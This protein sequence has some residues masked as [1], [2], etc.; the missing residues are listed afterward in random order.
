MQI[1]IPI[2]GTYSFGKVKND[3]ETDAS[4][5][6]FKALL[7]GYTPENMPITTETAMQVATVIRCV[8]VVAKNIAPLPLHL[9]RTTS[10]GSEKAKDLMLYSMLHFLPNKETTAYEFWT[11]YLYNIMLTRAAYAYISRDRYGNPVELYNLPSKYCQMKRNKETGERYV[12]YRNGE[13]ETKIYPENLMYTPNARFSDV[14][15][16]LDPIVLASQVLRL[17][18]NLNIFADNYFANGTQSSGVVTL[19]NAA[20]EPVFKQFKKDFTEAYAGVNNSSKILFLNGNSKFEK[21]VNNPNDSQALE[22][23]QAQIYEICRVMGVTPFKVFEYGRATY[24]NLEE[25]NL[26]FVQETINPMA[27][28]LEQTISRD[29]IFPWLRESLYPKFNLDGLLRGDTAAR[30]AFYNIMRQNGI[31]NANDIR[32]K[33]DMNLIPEAEGGNAYLCNGNMISL[34]TAMKAQPKS[35]QKGNSQ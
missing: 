25:V 29:L 9:Y 35:A 10:N 6:R 30:S 27:V 21:L 5:E 32:E 11:M 26:E 18:S 14:D 16:P 15:N 2:L 20:T 24:S 8:D 23:R 12:L 28:R 22:S 34:A 3:A 17:T 1:K 19:T 7:Y 33:E 31:L 13:I 4:W